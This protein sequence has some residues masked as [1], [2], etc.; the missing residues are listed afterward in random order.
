[1]QKKEVQPRVQAWDGEIDQGSG[2]AAA[3]AARDLHE[4]V[5]CKWVRELSTDPQHAFPGQMKPEQLEID[6][7]R[8]EVAKLKAQRDILKNRRG[9]PLGGRNVCY[10]CRRRGIADGLLEA[11]DPLKNMAHGPMRT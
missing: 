7:L 11:S 1:M 3:Q 9:P 10:S 5:L 8:K 2:V 6:R 4:N